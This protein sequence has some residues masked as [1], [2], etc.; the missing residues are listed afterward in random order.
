M[1]TPIANGQD[2]PPGDDNK[3]IFLRDLAKSGKHDNHII[4]ILP[5]A[6]SYLEMLGSWKR[7]GGQSNGKS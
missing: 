2:Y 7:K 3:L 1:R 4:D 6:C 5:L